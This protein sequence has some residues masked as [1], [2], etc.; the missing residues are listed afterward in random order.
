MLPSVTEY[1]YLELVAVGLRLRIRNGEQH[2]RSGLL[3]VPTPLDCRELRLLQLVNA[4]AVQMAESVLARR[5]RVDWTK[6]PYTSPGCLIIVA[7]V[8]SI[9]S[10]PG[11]E[12]TQT[13]SKS[14]YI[15]T[16]WWAGGVV[17]CCAIA[18]AKADGALGCRTDLA[19][20]A[21]QLGAPNQTLWSASRIWNYMAVLGTAGGVP[22]AIPS[23]PSVICW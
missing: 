7:S 21:R 22:T 15:E 3:I 18:F 4:V 12:T 2:F 17:L 9:T 10:Q 13:F 11:S 5:P 23:V 14:L 1:R 6:V 20:F 16:T 8:S 19:A